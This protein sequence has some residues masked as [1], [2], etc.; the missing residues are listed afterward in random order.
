MPE[1]NRLHIAKRLA[2]EW[3]SPTDYVVTRVEANGNQVNLVINGSGEPPPVSALGTRL[4]ATL[5]RFIRLR[6]VIVPTATELY[7]AGPD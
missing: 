4:G 6:V 3:V 7:E 2:Q 1:R 5:D